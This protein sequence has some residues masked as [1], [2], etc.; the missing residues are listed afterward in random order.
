MKHFV[1]TQLFIRIALKKSNAT[2]NAALRLV[3]K[4]MHAGVWVLTAMEIYD[5]L[6]MKS[7]K[8]S[9][10]SPKFKNTYKKIL[11]ATEKT[12]QKKVLKDLLSW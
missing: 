6:K 10:K 8:T 1:K 12:L 11:H 4:S 9:K 7:L 2:A 5:I 3:Q